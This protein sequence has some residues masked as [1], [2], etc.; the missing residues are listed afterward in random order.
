MPALGDEPF[1]AV[2]IRAPLIEDVGPDVEVLA[3][4]PDGTPVAAQQ[5]NMLVTAFHPELTDDLRFHR[6]FLAM[7]EAAKKPEDQRL[8][9]RGR[10]WQSIG[11]FDYPESPAKGHSWHTRCATPTCSISLNIVATR[12]KQRVLRLNPPYTLVQPEAC[13]PTCW[14]PRCR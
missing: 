10:G 12:R 13:C 11:N 6:Y 5:G 4:L 2:F 1:P 7:V 3:R 14:A 8:E 9:I